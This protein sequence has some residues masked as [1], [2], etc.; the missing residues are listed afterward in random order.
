M[1][2]SLFGVLCIL[3]GTVALLPNS[4]AQ[5]PSYPDRAIELIVP[6]TAG[7]A[8]DLPARVIAT[9]LS[10]KWKKPIKIVN[11][12]GGGFVVG[13]QSV[14]QAEPDGYTILWDGNGAA[15]FQIM[16]KDKLPYKWDGRTF[17]G[18]IVEQPMVFLVNNSSPMKTLKDVEQRI[19]S[20]PSSFKSS[21]QAITTVTGLS[22]VRWFDTINVD[23]S[24]CKLIE[25]R[26]SKEAV[27][28]VAGGHIDFASGGLSSVLPMIQSGHVRLVAVLSSKRTGVLPDVP[29]A[30]EQGYPI[31]LSAW[32]GIS[33]P[34]NLPKEVVDKWVSAMEEM[35]EDKELAA[36]LRSKLKMDISFLGPKE[37]K[38]MVLTE[39]DSVMK[40]AKR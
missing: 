31:E 1:R 4:E 36:E 21:W 33:G 27:T 2:K 16:I 6:Q 35:A 17:I 30:K 40:F 9:W 24:K 32:Q 18:K 12:P 20:N 23:P 22:L 11:R 25:Y 19:R 28:A 5:Q 34:P 7:S 26:A 29:T 38:E 13:T 10:E 14:M 37:F 39:A 3:F 8:V 15:S